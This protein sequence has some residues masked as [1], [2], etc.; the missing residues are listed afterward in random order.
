MNKPELFEERAHLGQGADAL[1]PAREAA[2]AASDRAIL[3]ALPPAIV[4]AEVERRLARR[5]RARGAARRTR[6]VAFAAAAATAVVLIVAL[7]D[8]G[9]ARGGRRG[10][11]SSELDTG[12]GDR[13]KGE[14]RLVVHRRRGEQIEELGRGE[15]AAPGDLLQISYVAAGRRYG[16]I[17]SLD[18]RGAVTR[19][20]PVDGGEA[21]ALGRGEA[22]A[23]DR[24]YELDDAPGFERFVL[25][26]AADRFALAELLD[27]ARA[28]AARP[29][30]ATAALAL[31]AGFEQHDFLLR[32]D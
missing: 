11:A 25:V 32:K 23:L 8:R 20:L 22:V 6:V 2:L 19:H 28:L 30:A 14:P 24:A 10:D 21:V 26:T 1:D 5:R 9:P 7:A 4:A 3:E 18:G 27:A 17:V 16:A 13:V 12:A 15:R 31:P 29:D